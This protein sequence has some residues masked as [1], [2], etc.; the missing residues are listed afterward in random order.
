M[1]GWVENLNG[2]KNMGSK[3]EL[4]EKIEI[5]TRAMSFINSNLDEVRR[6]VYHAEVYVKTSYGRNSLEPL[7]NLLDRVKKEFICCSQ[8]LE[9][10]K[11]HYVGEHKKSFE[12][13][14]KKIQTQIDAVE[15]V[16][17]LGKEIEDIFKNM[18][19]K[20]FDQEVAKHGQEHE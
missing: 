20:I 2:G 18:D 7:E 10:I 15:K 12:A 9:K 8:N 14:V 11:S 6:M 19:L 3:N 1:G 5:Q 13:K 4:K 16:R 17:R